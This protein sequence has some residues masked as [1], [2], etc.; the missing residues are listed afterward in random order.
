MVC[1][2]VRILRPGDNDDPQYDYDTVAREIVLPPGSVVEAVF[3][4]SRRLEALTFWLFEVKRAAARIDP[5]LGVVGS[6]LERSAEREASEV[7]R[8]EKSRH[9]PVFHS[10][11]GADMDAIAEKL[12]AGML[13]DEYL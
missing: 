12:K 2:T 9:F 13:I 6:L 1:Y 7:D 5:L 3:E 10:L 8:P 11:S 4:N